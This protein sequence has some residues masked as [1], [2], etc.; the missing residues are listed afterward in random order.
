MSRKALTQNSEVSSE[1]GPQNLAKS[2]QNVAQEFA[3]Q[4]EAVQ[5]RMEADPTSIADQRYGLLMQIKGIM[6][7][8]NGLEQ[9]NRFAFRAQVHE[10]RL[11]TFLNWREE[12]YAALGVYN[13]MLQIIDL[14]NRR[15]RDA[16][17]LESIIEYRMMQ[18]STG[19]AKTWRG[20]ATSNY[21]DLNLNIDDLYE[22]LEHAII[23]DYAR[24]EEMFAMRGVE[25]DAAIVAG[26]YAYEAMEKAY[27]AAYM[28]LLTLMDDVNE[29]YG[30]KHF[31]ISNLEYRRYLSDLHFETIRGEQNTSI[32]EK[33]ILQLMIYA[34]YNGLE[35]KTPIDKIS[36]SN[37][38]FNISDLFRVAS[39]V[40]C[41]GWMKEYHKVQ[42]GAEWEQIH[43]VFG[44]MMALTEGPLINKFRAEVEYSEPLQIVWDKV[45]QSDESKQRIADGH[46]GDAIFQT[47]D[48]DF[49][50]SGELTGTVEAYFDF[51]F[52]YMPSPQYAVVSFFAGDPGSG[53]STILS[54]LAAQTVI[55]HKAPVLIPLSETSNWPTLAFMPYMKMPGNLSYSFCAEEVEIPPQGVPVLILNIVD[56]MDVLSGEVMTKYDR[57]IK[58]EK[59]EN[60][61]IDI[62]DCLNELQMIA[63]GPEFGYDRPAGIIAVRNLGRQWT[64]D[65]THKPVDMELR[66]A[67]N[68]WYSALAWKMKHTQMPMRS[69]L[70]EAADAGTNNPSMRENV[71]MRNQI[72]KGVR[73]ARRFG[74]AMDIATQLTREI[75]PQVRRLAANT[76]WRGLTSDRSDAESP[77]ENLLATFACDDEDKEIVRQMTMSKIF[78]RKQAKHLMF[79]YNRLNHEINLVQPMPSPF[80]P[81]IVSKENDDIYKIYCKRTNTPREKLI[82]KNLGVW[83]EAGVGDV[84]KEQVEKEFA[85]DT[86][87]NNTVIS[88]W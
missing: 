66:N 38:Y 49:W 47:I 16:R 86:K 65:K 81:Q 4:Q 55:E 52:R 24:I 22:R 73:S 36:G 31:Q 71:Q 13:T 30:W 35:L 6:A 20:I 74:M 8:F 79:W 83:R 58:V 33:A 75:S 63:E 40:Q 50:R 26:W 25:P 69:I 76:F 37:R 10:K 60:F 11:G 45:G 17:E 27:A 80:M 46:R 77:L 78:Q 18:I 87:S 15:K 2:F 82:I 9:F 29:A 3:A 19:N 12:M 28:T 51:D 72:E 43:R 14:K 64:D 68:V 34:A 54:R 7:G 42:F 62:P 59:Y 53:K 44:E 85:L 21:A 88:K 48:Q 5:E 67:I 39:N 41:I 84:A 1:Y 57:I 70:D 61:A 23:N 56:N 32:D